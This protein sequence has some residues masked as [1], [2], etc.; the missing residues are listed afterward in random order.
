[1]N[2]EHATLDNRLKAKSEIIIITVFM[3]FELS[4]FKSTPF[5]LHA[6]NFQHT[7][8]MYDGRYPR[9]FSAKYGELRK[10]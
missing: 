4:V 10:L 6:A 2:N 8:T 1:M 5:P 9:R 3:R 7:V